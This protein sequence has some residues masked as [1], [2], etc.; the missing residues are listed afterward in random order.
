M[1]SVIIPVYN[2]E[3]YLDE[4][5]RSIVNQSYSDL[6]IIIIDDCSTDNS[7]SVIDQW[8]QRDSRILAI[9]NEKQCG[10]SFSRNL[11]IKR[12]RG[13][14][15]SF[16]DS[17]DYTDPLMY[18]HLLKIMEKYSVDLVIF[19][20]LTV[21][22]DT[23]EETNLKI[24][25][26]M[27]CTGEEA[28][29]ICL[30]AIRRGVVN[31]FSWNRL[32]RRSLI[33]REAGSEI[34]FDTGINYCEDVVW[35][36]ELLPDVEKVVFCGEPLYFYR[37]FR[38]GNSYTGKLVTTKYTHSAVTAYQIAYQNLNAHHLNCAKNAFQR[39]LQHRLIGMRIAK[40]ASD[41]QTFQYCNKGFLRDLFRWTKMESSLYGLIWTSKKII[42]YCLFQMGVIK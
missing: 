37:N 22:D 13:E 18:E 12:A 33:I 2:T 7:G 26:T 39:S 28:T 35:Q 4:C 27:V 14:Y 1:I 23:I 16:V 19:P 21:T 17:D 38:K 3:S 34:L 8:A 10:V 11:G 15:L 9:H 31:M 20:W 41:I 36:T 30:P 40:R 5:I 25:D 29:N 6:E 24:E 32:F 42:Q